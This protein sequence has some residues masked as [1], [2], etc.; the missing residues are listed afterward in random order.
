MP[1]IHR[2]S[3]RQ[4]DVRIPVLVAGRQL[5]VPVQE[6]WLR[7]LDRDGLLQ[8]AELIG[9]YRDKNAKKPKR[10]SSRRWTVTPAV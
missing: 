2:K 4:D 8:A 3:I 10:C 6:K 9:I 5:F 1:D 7:Q